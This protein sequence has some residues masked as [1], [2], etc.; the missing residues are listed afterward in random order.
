[1]FKMY[2]TPMSN[3]GRGHQAHQSSA[4]PPRRTVDEVPSSGHFITRL[5]GSPQPLLEQK[6]QRARAHTDIGVSQTSSCVCTWLKH[7]CRADAP[8]LSSS[9]TTIQICTIQYPRGSKPAFAVS[10]NCYFS[11]LCFRDCNRKKRDT[12]THTRMK[13]LFPL[14]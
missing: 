1:M 3:T 10:H 13:I 4:S 9:P 2:F 8:K 14:T 5:R 6:F 11:L 7:C 12:H